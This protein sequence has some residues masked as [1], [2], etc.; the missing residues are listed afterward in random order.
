MKKLNS[1]ELNQR[2]QIFANADTLNEYGEPVPGLELYWDTSAKV[3][4]VRSARNLQA[5]QE[6][7]K[8]VY[9]F[10][11]RNRRDKHISADDVVRWKGDDGVVLS[12]EVDMVYFEYLTILCKFERIPGSV[13]TV[14]A[15]GP[16]IDG[17]TQVLGTGS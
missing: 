4:P 12:V 15:I 6:V 5:N 16:D 17:V 14:F 7:L 10:T 1:G 2:I 9:S 13:E 11:V 8:P 3:Q